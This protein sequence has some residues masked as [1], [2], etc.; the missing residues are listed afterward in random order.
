MILTA[1]AER[2]SEYR[3]Q[4][5][6]MKRASSGG[7]KWWDISWNP[8]TGCTPISPGCDHCYARTMA[9][10]LEAMGEPHYQQRRGDLS[11]T[12]PGFAVHVHPDRLQRAADRGFGRKP[13]RI[14][15]CSM[16][17][18]FH[19]EVSF[20]VANA[21]MLIAAMNPHHT[22]I[23]LTKRAHRMAEFFR[24]R[25]EGRDLG[26]DVSEMDVC[27]R[28]VWVGVTVE[29]QAMANRRIPQLLTIVEASVRWVSCEPL[30]GPVDLLGW[31][32]GGRF[33]RGVDWAVIGGESGPGARLMDL[34]WARRIADIAAARPALFPVWFKQ[35]GDAADHA[36]HGATWVEDLR[37]LP[38]GHP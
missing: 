36:W 11:G 19:D 7:G 9:R 32:A 2:Q 15:V 16:S 38:K 29:N 6:D 12:E 31:A 23:V 13:R 24:H 10:R 1:R 17:D 35:W 34:R 27:P 18:L 3:Q 5:D 26:A 25:R 28:N 14:F 21:V 4:G 30:L 33:A 8:V 37:G 20:T 22:F